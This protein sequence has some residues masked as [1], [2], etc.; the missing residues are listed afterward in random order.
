MNNRLQN[1]IYKADDTEGLLEMR[2]LSLGEILELDQMVQLKKAL[3]FAKIDSEKL[4][5]T[6]KYAWLKMLIAAFLGL[7]LGYRFTPQILGFIKLYITHKILASC[8][9]S[10]LTLTSICNIFEAGSVSF[11]GDM[12]GNIVRYIKELATKNQPQK[13][14]EETKEATENLLA[15]FMQHI[16]TADHEEVGRWVSIAEI[17]KNLESKTGRTYELDELDKFLTKKRIKQKTIDGAK[18][19]LIEAEN[20]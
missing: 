15:D 3:F 9:I 19:Y 4:H 5:T 20:A 12:T 14:F 6:K 1:I 7:E 11:I 18:K 8:T 10:V 16:I 13:P 2:K 17:Q